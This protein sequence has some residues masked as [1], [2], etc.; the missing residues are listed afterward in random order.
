MT[1][2]LTILFAV[3]FPA[4]LFA[5]N[6]EPYVP[7]PIKAEIYDRYGGGRGDSLVIVYNKSFV[8][9]ETGRMDILPNYIE[10]FWDEKITETIGYGLGQKENDVYVFRGNS[11]ENIAYWQKYL[12]SGSD[13]II[14]ITRDN[15]DESFSGQRVKTA[16][17][18]RVISWATF[19]NPDRPGNLLTT[20]NAKTI[21]EKIQPIVISARYIGDVNNCGTRDNPCTDYVII[22]VSEPL[23]LA[24]DVDENAVK[25]AFAYILRSMNRSGEFKVFDRQDDLPAIVRWKTSG[26]ATP[27]PGGDST[28]TLMYRAYRTATDTAFTP[29]AVDSIRFLAGRKGGYDPYVFFDVADPSKSPLVDL[30]GNYPHPRE[31]GVLITGR[32]RFGV[33]KI[34][35]ASLDRGKDIFKEI[36]KDSLFKKGL[37]TLFNDKKPVAFLPVDYWWEGYWWELNLDDIRRC[38]PGSV[39]Y[40]LRPDVNNNVFRIELNEGVDIPPENITFH[41]EVSY[42]SAVEKKSIEIKCN[43]PIFQ[44][45]GAGN[46]RNSN[47]YRN[48]NKGVYV[49][50]NL[51]DDAGNFVNDG[52][53]IQK[54]DFHWEVTYMGKTIVFDEYS[55]TQIVNVGSSNTPI[56][57]PQI[58]NTNSAFA[59]QNAIYLQT[60]NPGRLDIYNMKGKLE[61]TL[62]FKN[63]VYT[64]SLGDLQKGMYVAKVTFGSEKQIL[65]VVVR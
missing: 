30:K 10:I 58:S 48:G 62:H 51:K 8:N 5:Q 60:Q 27:A 57:L 20:G 6:E 2:T 7:Y 32:Q 40:L 14:V 26:R 28:V 12:L 64:I 18:G 33:G 41:A 17:E 11:N 35:I 4:I 37:D 65:R 50:W 63:G 59:A 21:D 39:G 31:W 55:D 22:D 42:L 52:N 15:Y 1:K 29:L 61:K 13:S 49:A 43:D 34:S 38:Y 19:D 16:G 56:R 44:I 9:P 25:T 46:C 54:I 36:L 53:Y 23:K 3:L 45:N 47:I 24:E